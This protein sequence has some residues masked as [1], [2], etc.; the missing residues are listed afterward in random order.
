M[1][2][3][4]KPI[5]YNLNDRGRVH[6][7]QDRSNVNVQA[8][9]NKINS[10]LV[11]EQVETGCL[12]GFCGHQ[13]RQRYGMIPPETAML[14]NT[15]TLLEPATRTVYLK[16]EDDGTVTHKQ[17]FLEN[18]KGDHVLRQYKG[19]IGGFS[20]AVNYIVNGNELLPNVF[21][22]F[23]YVFAQN[24]IENASIGL[25]DSAM[26][27][28]T[29]KYIHSMLENEIVAMYDSISEASQNYEY[30]QA[31]SARAK[32]AERELKRFKN[33]TRERVKRR[34]QQELDAYDSALCSRTMDF[35]LECKKA[36]E[37]LKFKAAEIA[38]KK[39]EE[40]QNVIKANKMMVTLG[41]FLGV[42]Q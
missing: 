34:Q 25:F 8:M 1:S 17:E 22:G 41:K 32:N 6:T 7:G 30:M 3:I 28:D 39:T 12:Y 19:K 5:T 26:S 31:M 36:E 40:D 27:D 18:P 14:G 16:A 42:S 13:I 24:F 9:I 23:D 10:P 37:F 29:L 2:R 4:T 11:Q 33:Q 15:L 21:G 38:P 20:T 35:E